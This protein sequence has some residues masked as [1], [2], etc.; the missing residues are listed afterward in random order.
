MT[1]PKFTKLCQG[2]VRETIESRM[3]LV[4]ACD[5]A[6]LSQVTDTRDVH[7]LDTLQGGARSDPNVH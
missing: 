7:D 1:D 2:I 6:L 5:I 4:P 3:R